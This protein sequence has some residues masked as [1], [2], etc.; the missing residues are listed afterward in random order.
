MPPRVELQDHH[1][2]EDKAKAQEDP[3][4]PTCLRLL[5][6]RVLDGGEVVSADCEEHGHAAIDVDRSGRAGQENLI[7]LAHPGK[8]DLAGAAGSLDDDVFLRAAFTKVIGG[9]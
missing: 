9:R 7:L 2:A 5:N 8:D 1:A 4:E 6:D 3:A